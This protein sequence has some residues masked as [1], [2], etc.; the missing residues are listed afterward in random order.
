MGDQWGVNLV[1]TDQSTNHRCTIRLPCIL[2]ILVLRVLCI[3]QTI[4]DGG[5]I[6][7]ADILTRLLLLLL[8]NHL[9]IQRRIT[10][11]FTAKDTF[12]EEK[13]CE[14]KLFFFAFVSFLEN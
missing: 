9:I 5:T 13:A 7:V 12:T 3:L 4:S 11:P 8:I 10:E 2:C 1:A 14:Q 6:L